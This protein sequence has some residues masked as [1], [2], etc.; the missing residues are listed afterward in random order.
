MEGV[1]AGFLSGFQLVIIHL[2]QHDD[3]QEIFA[4]LNG[5]G[6]PLSPFDLIRNDVF[7]RARKNKENEDQL[8]DCRWKL[9][10]EPFW[11]EEVRQGR[12]KRARADH[13]VAHAVVAE[14]AREVNVGKIAAEY[15]RYSE[16]RDYATI[17]DELDVLLTHATTY[18][19]MEDGNT[20]G[21]LAR[22]S[23]VLRIWD[24]S[25]FHPIIF[26]INAQLMGPTDRE[27]LFKLLESYIVRREICGL[28]TKNYNKVITSMLRQFKELKG[29][30][31]PIAALKQQL[32]AEL[33]G[34]A[35]RM[36]RD[37]EIA[38]ACARTKAYRHIPTRRLV[39]I[40]R[41]IE[42]GMRSSIDE[43][44]VMADNL[45]V[46]HIMP[47]KWAE[48]W[49]LPNGALA[50]AESIVQASKDGKELSDETKS[51]MEARQNLVDTLGN[52][53]LLTDALNPSIGNGPWKEKKKKLAGSLLALNRAVAAREEWNEAAIQARAAVLASTANGLW[54]VG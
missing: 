32:F 53:T 43:V 37:V 17:A 31:R 40:L 38:E 41:Q 11:T 34:D 24:L 44:T 8:F 12:S 9:L 35:S 20:Q 50:P 14:T 2:D 18:K 27:Q 23:S 1:L 22:I 3:A 52:L 49:P 21:P 4:S 15:Q 36:P 47:Q 51:Q 25:T 26:R 19:A 39:Y 7:H 29:G 42:H 28:T 5:F 46:E 48:H 6:K 16:E 45:T 54:P 13:L 33:T 30:P 10:E